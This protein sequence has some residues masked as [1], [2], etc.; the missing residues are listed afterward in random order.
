MSTQVATSQHLRIGSPVAVTFPTTGTKTY[1]VQ[2]IYSVRELAGDYILP[3]AAAEANFPQALDIDV[4]V[5]L[6]PG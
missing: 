6:A 1:T 5:K 2:V 4:F 3:L